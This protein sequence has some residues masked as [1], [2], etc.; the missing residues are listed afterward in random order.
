[1]KRWQ[2]EA[3]T[4][5]MPAAF[6][7]LAVFMSL[8][9]EAAAFDPPVVEVP[10]DHK[11]PLVSHDQYPL[12]WVHLTNLP[13]R[14]NIQGV[15][16]TTDG[17]YFAGWT[18]DGSYEAMVG[19]LD[20]SGNVDW[21]VSYGTE[22]G[23]FA[24]NITKYSDYLYV[25]GNTEGDFANAGTYADGFQDGFV[26]K[27][28]LSGNLIW[29]RQ[30]G[31]SEYEGVTDGAAD[32]DGNYFV[33]GSTAPQMLD[34][35]GRAAMLAKFNPNG[36]LQWRVE[37][38]NIYEDSGLAVT[39]DHAGNSFLAGRTEDGTLP[40]LNK[41][42]S[43]GQLVWEYVPDPN[44]LTL[45]LGSGIDVVTDASGNSYL[46][47]SAYIESSTQIERQGLFLLKFDAA[48][49]QVW[50]RSV[51]S[52]DPP[53][54]GFDDE[55]YAL[56]MTMNL[57]GNLLIAGQSKGDFSLDHTTAGDV[58]VLEFTPDGELVVAQQYGDS[59]YQYANE[60][61]ADPAGGLYV[62][63]TTWGD[64]EGNQLPSEDAFVMHLTGPTSVP[65]PSTG[66]LCASVM[67]AVIG[68]HRMR[69]LRSAD[70]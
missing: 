51:S 67:L 69:R 66:L 70:K 4:S 38:D 29:T 68:V 55:D 61:S 52:S 37:K 10:V 6:S 21:M 18:V 48:G 22:F 44:A 19:K 31:G 63:G 34:E 36:E 30:F 53:Y 16:A 50:S 5:L 45:E 12:D 28:D 32:L 35:Y 42:D 14:T 60:I 33:A 13:G 1:M 65:E 20:R 58:V 27:F 24:S 47:Y 56:A 39:T 25:G 43:S 23:D 8:A 54:S 17:A 46:T 26:S 15:Q 3:L 49:N 11:G 40:F 59:N 57:E 64:F 2:L 7:A 9:S 62:V 41:Y